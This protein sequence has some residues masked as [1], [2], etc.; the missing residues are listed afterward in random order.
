VYYAKGLTLEDER[1]L[2]NAYESAKSGYELSLLVNKTGVLAAFLG[3]T[4]YVSRR[5]HPVTVGLFSLGWYLAYRDV[6]VPFHRNRFQNSLNYAAQPIAAK[7]GLR[8]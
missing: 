4:Y 7:Y 6:T 5:V 1:N 3:S 2:R 8:Q